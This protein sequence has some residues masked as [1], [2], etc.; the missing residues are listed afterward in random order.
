MRKKRDKEE[1]EVGKELILAKKEGAG[2]GSRGGIVIKR[3]KRGRG[4]V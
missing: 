1:G 2:R 4:K 3:G